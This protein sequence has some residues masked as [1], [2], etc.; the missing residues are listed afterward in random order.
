M[1]VYSTASELGEPAYA[2]C[3]KDVVVGFVVI[4]AVVLL[5][6]AAVAI[7]GAAVIMVVDN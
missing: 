5:V 4:V 7:P 2:S 6:V 1:C 3:I